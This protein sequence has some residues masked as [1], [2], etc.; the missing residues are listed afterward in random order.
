MK[1]IKWLKHDNEA[2]LTDDDLQFTL[3]KINEKKIF[4]IKEIRK[5]AIM[6]K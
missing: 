6:S 4:F 3:N 5:N 1:N 2:R